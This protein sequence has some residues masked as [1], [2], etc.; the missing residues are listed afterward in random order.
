M[1]ARFLEAARQDLREA[2]LYYESQRPGLGKEFREEVRSTVERIKAL[3]DA[4][5]L[6][7]ENTRRCRT[8][9]FPYG[10]I[11]QARAE[12]VVIVAVAHLHQE[13]SRWRDRL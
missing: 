6:L 5:Q 12:E 1:R 2:A 4:W 13:P 8:R 3:P 7:G 11:Y 9:R 10:V